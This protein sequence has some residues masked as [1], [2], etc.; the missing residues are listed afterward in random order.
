MTTL[1]AIDG[2]SLNLALKRKTTGSER[3]R[4]S[5]E[6]L[7]QYLRDQVADHTVLRYYTDQQGTNRY[8]GTVLQF[9]N[10]FGKIEGYKQDRDRERTFSLHHSNIMN[11]GFL[12]KRGVEVPQGNTADFAHLVTNQVVSFDIEKTDEGFKAINV[13]IEPNSSF[14][15]RI[16][17]EK[18]LKMLEESGFEVIRNRISN[19]PKSKSK[20]L[21]MKVCIDSVRELDEEDTFLILT[22][23]SEYITLLKDLTKHGVR[24]II[25]CFLTKATEEMRKLSNSVINLDE[26]IENISLEDS[27]SSTELQSESAFV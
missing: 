13:L 11:K 20:S 22:Q 26:I 8:I 10:G 17:S 7:G 21:D 24:I 1:I 18:F 23:D 3:F 25:A 15:S 2:P 27:N 16:K 4:I 19:N 14:R 6:S 5:Y 12:T 9:K